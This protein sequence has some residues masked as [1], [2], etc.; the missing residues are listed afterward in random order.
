MHV[1]TSVVSC[2][3]VIFDIE[4]WLSIITQVICLGI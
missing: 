2:L 4:E 1:Y 3:R